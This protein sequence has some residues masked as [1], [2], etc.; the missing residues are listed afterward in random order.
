MS[1]QQFYE[2]VQRE[3]E[4]KETMMEE[5]KFKELFSLNV[6]DRTEQK[7]GLTY[8]SWAWAWAEFKKAYPNAHY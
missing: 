8:L 5:N 7:D 4:Y 2:T 6:N 1:Q 3:Q